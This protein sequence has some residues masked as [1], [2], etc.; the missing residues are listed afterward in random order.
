MHELLSY[1]SHRGV[2]TFLV[3]AQAEIVGMR[4]TAP[5]D[6]SYLADNM[7]LAAIFRI[8]RRGSQSYLRR[9]DA[10]LEPRKFDS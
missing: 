3:L 10:R 9:K 6:I 1:L 5:L 2:A 8:R 7:L 4:M